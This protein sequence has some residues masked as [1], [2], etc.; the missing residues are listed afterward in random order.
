MVGKAAAQTAN[1]RPA[2]SSSIGCSAFAPSR[3]QPRCA[4]RPAAFPFAGD[5]RHGRQRRAA[6][7]DGRQARSAWRC[8]RDLR[9]CGAAA[10]AAS[11][12]GACVRPSP[13]AAAALL[14]T[15]TGRKRSA[16]GLSVAVSI[17]RMI[18][19]LPSKCS[20]TAVQLSTQSPVLI[21]SHAV[22]L[23]DRGM[24]DMA[25]DDAVDTAAARFL[26]HD[27]LEMADE[28]DRLLDLD[29]RPGR[30]RPVGHAEQPAQAAD[31]AID[32]DRDVVGPV[33]EI[34]EPAHIVDDRIEL[35][36]VDDQE[37]AAVRGWCGWPGRRPRCR[38]NGCPG[39]VAGTR[40]DCPRHR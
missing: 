16:T 10:A 14:L 20:A 18:S 24:V 25:A 22:H 7:H 38:R 37:I 27:L 31:D 17:Q 29:L 36:A 32:D 2:R 1:R 9:T 21:Y 15:M 28:V 6:A 19:I 5:V 40:R 4:T 26:R 35:I 11:N 13:Q 30:E 39:R 3:M 23:L 8:L 12:G 34:G 33:A